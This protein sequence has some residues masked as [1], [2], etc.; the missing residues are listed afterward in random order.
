M[1]REQ[2]EF[3]IQMAQSNPNMLCSE[4]S[5]EILEAASFSGDEPAEFMTLYF[6]A[7]HVE[8]IAQTYKRRIHLEQERI[9][10]AVYV[11]WLRASNLYTSRITGRDD[12]DWKQ[13][14]FSDEGLY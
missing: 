10:R 1:D 14:I 13:P 7:G 6:A 4:A 2:E 8:W 9:D 12:P 3:H 11:L 5:L